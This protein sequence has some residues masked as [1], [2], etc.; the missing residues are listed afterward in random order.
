MLPTIRTLIPFA[1]DQNLGAAYNAEMDALPEGG[2]A[3]LLDH[4]VMFTTKMWYSQMLAAIHTKPEG[5]FTGLTNRISITEGWQI[6]QGVDRDN[7]NVMYHRALGHKLM[8]QPFKLEDVTGA[9][10]PTR[11]FCL[12]VSKSTWRKVGGF[13][14]GLLGVDFGFHFRLRAN[15]CPLYCIRNLYLYHFYRADGDM[16]ILRA[17]HYDFKK[18][19]GYKIAKG[20]A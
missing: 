5:T 18:E 4:D 11:G 15:L 13:P 17:P 7:H 1:E 12:V 6:P 3:C 9:Y 14:D 19:P 2:W 20:F 10:Q 8:Q 16:A